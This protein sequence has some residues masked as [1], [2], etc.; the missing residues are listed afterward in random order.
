MAGY[1]Y[2]CEQ[3]GDWEIQRP[4]GTAQATS[5]CPTCG[6]PGRRL[7]TAPRLGRLPKATAAA[8]Q[9]EEAS[10]DVP[11]VVT[12]LPSRASRTAPRDPRWSKLPRP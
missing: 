10:R 3:C 9:A 1:L 2:R 12:S 11:Q 7:Y 6:A 5:E 4:I 8:R